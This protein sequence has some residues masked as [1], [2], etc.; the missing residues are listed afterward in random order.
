MAEWQ[1]VAV[2]GRMAEW[3]NGRMAE[4]GSKWLVLLLLVWILELPQNNSTSLLGPYSSVLG[5]SRCAR[6]P[7]SPDDHSALII[8]DPRGIVGQQLWPH[9]I[10]LLNIF[11]V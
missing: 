4:C 1:N 7:R 3:Q 8:G 10:N 11:I 6:W 9:P 5:R 2:N